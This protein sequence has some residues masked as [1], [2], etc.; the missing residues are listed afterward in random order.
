MTKLREA[1]HDIKFTKKFKVFKIPKNYIISY[2][3]PFKKALDMFILILAI[4][5]SFVV[6]WEFAFLSAHEKE[7][8]FV[9]DEFIDTIFFIDILMSFFTSSLT[10]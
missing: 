7:G 10:K 3:S 8:S 2:Q 1:K 4:F 5:N 9:I 6:P